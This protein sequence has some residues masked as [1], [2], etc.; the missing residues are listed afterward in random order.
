I[1]VF[2]VA[3]GRAQPVQYNPDLFD[4]GALKRPEAEDLGFAGFRIHA[5][6][7]RPDYFDEVCAF[8]GASY[9][10]AVAREQRY[11]L[12]ARGLAI[13]TADQA[14]EE[15]PL[16]RTFWI[17]KPAPGSRSIVVHALLDSQSTTGAF[18]FTIR[19]GA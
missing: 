6:F 4:F 9:F 13:K 1:D 3:D 10:R 7:N 14:G 12:S 15:F 11:G 8:V 16:F 2:Q 18:R 19:P 5:P 17:E